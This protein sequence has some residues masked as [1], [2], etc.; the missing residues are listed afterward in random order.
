MLLIELKILILQSCTFFPRTKHVVNE[1]IFWSSVESHGKLK[2]HR[3]IVA[4]YAF[5]SRATVKRYRIPETVCPL[6][7][8]LHTTVKPH[9]NQPVLVRLIDRHLPFLCDL[10]FPLTKVLWSVPQGSRS[11]RKPGNGRTEIPRRSIILSNTHLF[12]SSS[13]HYSTICQICVYNSIL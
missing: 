4:C 10:G 7:S 1:F 8:I 3:L 9:G 2:S 11:S 13:T 12:L 5:H 6:E